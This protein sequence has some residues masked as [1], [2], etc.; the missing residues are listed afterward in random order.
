MS[1]QWHRV[2]RLHE[3]A[4]ARRLAA[5]QA[6]RLANLELTSGAERPVTRTAEPVTWEPPVN[7]PLAP[8]FREPV[9]ETAE[10]DVMRLMHRDA[11]DDAPQASKAD[12]ILTAAR[13]LGADASPADIAQHLAHHGLAVDTAYVRTVMSRARKAAEKAAEQTS[14]PASTRGGYL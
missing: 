10:G 4:D 11:S 14:N 1:A 8:V 7:L 2:E 3:N 13:L 5:T 6:D 12:A 9:S